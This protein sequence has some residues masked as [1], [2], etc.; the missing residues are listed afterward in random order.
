MS[1][2]GETID[3]ARNILLASRGLGGAGGAKIDPLAAITQK[4][5]A[6]IRLRTASR[7]ANRGLNQAR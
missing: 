1:H 3:V 4:G 7:N 6:A 2:S 5:R